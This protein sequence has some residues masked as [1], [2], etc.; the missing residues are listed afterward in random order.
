[1]KPVLQVTY[2]L[3]SGFSC[4]MDGVLL[5]FDYWLGEHQELPESR[6]ITLDM[7]RQYK[8]IYV[9]I[10][11]SHPDHF[12]PVVY[13]WWRDD[14]RL[15]ITYIVSDELPKGSWGRAMRP[16]EH[17]VL[18][19][20][21]EVTAFDSTDLGVSFL[22]TLDGIRIFHAGD[23]NFWHWRE[24]S[25][26]QEIAEAEEDFH[27]ACRPIEREVREHGVFDLCF[28]PLDP[29]QGS[30]YDAGANYFVMSVKPRLLVPMHFWERGQLISEYVR[31]N[32]SRSTEMIALTHPGDTM[33]LEFDEDGFMRIVLP[34]AP[35]AR[36]A[37]PAE[38]EPDP[39]TDSDLPVTLE[40]GDET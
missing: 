31:H 8:E 24:E 36:P 29:R 5:I 11:H 2:Y 37:P 23:L 21:A 17:S 28:F 15:P 18:S 32:R 38:T 22:V 27:N 12:D 40:D 6:R 7:L 13:S 1:M 3:H 19:E 33:T 34:S 30:L 4:A 35:P 25:T 26:A 39:F 20:R 10:T 16:G 9:F 14:P